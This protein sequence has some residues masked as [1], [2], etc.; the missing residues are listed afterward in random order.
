MTMKFSWILPRQRRWR[1]KLKRR[2]GL[3]RRRR[4]TF[5]NG[6]GFW[7]SFVFFFTLPIWREGVCIYLD[8]FFL[9]KKTC[10]RTMFTKIF[11][12]KVGGNP[13][14]PSL[15]LPE[16][17]SVLAMA[18]ALVLLV[19]GSKLQSHFFVFGGST[20]VEVIGNQILIVFFFRHVFFSKCIFIDVTF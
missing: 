17:S 3:S 16:V 14:H 11:F 6:A 18:W 7:N 13:S 4:Q 5:F 9:F 2:I 20:I 8:P 12:E 19:Y 15:I 10:T 1:Q